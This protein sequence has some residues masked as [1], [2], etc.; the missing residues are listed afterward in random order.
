MLNKIK[1]QKFIKFVFVGCTAFVSEYI[2]LEILFNVLNIQTFFTIQ[3]I[4]SSVNIY[5]ANMI[6]IAISLTVNFSLNKF[7]TFKS[8][9]DSKEQL[10]KFALVIIFNYIMN[11]IIFGVLFTTT[12]NLQLSKFVATGSQVLWTFFLYKYFVFKAQKNIVNVG[13]KLDAHI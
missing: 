6:A 1:N 2:S 5:L 12:N 10:F 3:F 9:G 13:N 11:N 7:L 4:N 8:S